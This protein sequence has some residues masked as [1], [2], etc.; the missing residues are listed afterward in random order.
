MKGIM[1][2]C[3]ERY[4]R[5]V[6]QRPA[7]KLKAATTPSLEDRNL[8]DQEIERP[9]DLIAI[10]ANVFMHRMCAANMFRLD[11]RRRATPSARDVSLWA[12][13]CDKKVSRLMRYITS[14]LDTTLISHIGDLVQV[15]GCYSSRNPASPETQA[16]HFQV[17]ERIVLGF[18]GTKDFR[19]DRRRREADII[20]M[21]CTLRVGLPGRGNAVVLP[22]S[23]RF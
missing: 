15:A 19:T 18:D 22:L 9:Q 23:W 10:A 20:A 21:E 12:R 3:A 6:G 5:R 8:S 11:S 16:L 2:Q 17:D 1:E 7:S 14:T 4:V 13:A